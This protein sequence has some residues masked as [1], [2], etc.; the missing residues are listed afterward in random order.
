MQHSKLWKSKFSAAK[1]RESSAVKH[2]DLF[3]R[4]RSAHAQ[5]QPFKTS[6]LRACTTY[7][8]HVILLNPRLTFIN[9]LSRLFA[10][11]RA[12]LVQRKYYFSREQ[13]KTRQVLRRSY[14]SMREKVCLN[15]MPPPPQKWEISHFTPTR[16]AARGS[17]IRI[18]NFYSVE[19][20][21]I[22]SFYRDV[23]KECCLCN[24]RNSCHVEGNYFRL[25]TNISHS[26]GTS[27]NNFR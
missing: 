26:S 24:F 22:K 17:L 18:L 16:C 14:K 27:L 15:R 8:E 13:K 23:C 5:I 7:A 20:P 19:H 11:L 21:L 2:I 3:W 12:Q 1:H 25:W 9:E 10:Q 4:L 6:H